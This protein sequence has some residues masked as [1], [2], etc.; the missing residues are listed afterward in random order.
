MP[1][2]RRR[3]GPAPVAAVAAAGVAVLC[4]AWPGLAGAAA[5]AQ[6]GHAGPGVSGQPDD[7][8]GVLRTEVDGAI[9]PVIAD[10]VD[11][12][13]DRAE[14]GGYD[15]LVIELDT[16]GG[17]DSAMRDVIR[18]VLE[19]EVPV[20]V[21]VSPRGARAASAGALIT[22]SAHVAAM[23]PGTAIGASTP[24]DLGG[25]EV[26][27]KVVNDSAAYAEALAELR[28]RDAEVAA[29]MVRDGRSL[30]VGEAIEEGVVDLEAGSLEELLDRVDGRVVDVG[31]GE[32][33]VTL[34]TAGAAVDEHEMGLLRRI[35]QA[36]ADPNLAFLF[37]SLGTLAIVYELAS[38]GVGAGGVVGVTLVVLGLFSLAV[39]PVSAV[40]VVL[41]VVAG[42]MFVAELF[43]PGIG[44]AAAGGT[45]ALVLSGVFLFRDVPGLE[46]SM[47][48]VVPVAVVVGAAV[49][50]AGRFVVRARRLPSRLSGSDVLIGQVATVRAAGAARQVFVGGA[51]WRVRDEGSPP[52]DGTVVR[53]V[54]VEGLDLVV[55]PLDRESRGQDHE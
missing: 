26:E 16:P 35:Q 43:A 39:L 36:L 47:A 42:A 21:H 6:H 50:A 10:H 5:D 31:P 44:V 15:L 34:R 38:P 41:L 11:A 17:L 1:G 25:G 13:V 33:E 4:M 40:G 9:T 14:D 29:E 23:A 46:V 19:A 8:A 51:W 28:G 2:S 37:L 7:G 53:I 45:G 48:V 49:V 52:D 12:A 30:P 18:R 20:A 55:E 27:D 3:V 24:V 32:R 22:L 54:G